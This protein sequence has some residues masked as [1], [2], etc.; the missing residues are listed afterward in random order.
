[1]VPPS[2]ASMKRA[3]EV[4]AC[5]P[6]ASPRPD[7]RGSGQRRRIGI[8]PPAG[9]LAIQETSAT[10]C[11]ESLATK[12]RG[13]SLGAAC[14]PRFPPSPRASPLQ[15]GAKRVKSRV[16]DIPDL[17][18]RDIPDLPAWVHR[19]AGMVRVHWLESASWL[20]PPRW[21][22]SFSK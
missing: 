5:G 12:R 19:A 22:D 6:P 21:T 17:V 16:R 8:R 20:T 9:G 15:G 7:G 11:R 10:A 4:F 14:R 1:V 3:A 18:G 2:G 13:R